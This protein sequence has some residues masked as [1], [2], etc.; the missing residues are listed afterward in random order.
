MQTVTRACRRLSLVVG[1]LAI[2][3]TCSAFSGC[4][5]PPPNLT[6]AANQAFYKTRA[7]KALDVIRDTAQD[8]NATTPPIVSTGTA[9]KVTT[10]HESALKIMHDA[11]AGWQ[12]AVATSL[13]ELLKDVTPAERQLL[14]PYV[15]LAKTILT[16]VAPS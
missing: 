2:V 10:W 11:G 13:D 3:V 1:L 5:P 15:A 12:T 6:P 14:A 8:G 4:A 16:E 9:R 7:Q